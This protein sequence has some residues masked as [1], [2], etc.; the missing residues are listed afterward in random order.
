MNYSI[1]RIE[2]SMAVCEDEQGH[3]IHIPL[4]DLPPGVY[5]GCVLTKNHSGYS[6]NKSEETKR[7]SEIQ[8]LQDELFE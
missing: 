8:T 5:E 6:I 7:R 2:E 3:M 4:K 1:D